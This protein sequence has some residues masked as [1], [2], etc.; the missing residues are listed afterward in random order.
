MA[1]TSSPPREDPSSEVPSNRQRQLAPTVGPEASGG[2]NREGSAMGSYDDS[3]AVGR[4]LYAGNFSSLRT[5]SGFRLGAAPQEDGAGPVQVEAPE[6]AAPDQQE[7]VGESGSPVE[8]SI[9]G[10]LSP[11]SGDTQSMDT[12]EFDRKV[13]EYGYGAQPEVDSAQPKQVLAT[14]A[15][16]GEHGSEAADTQSDPQPSRRGSPMS[17]ER[18]RRDPT[19]EDHLSTEDMIAQAAMDAAYPLDVLNTP[20]TP[21][22]VEALEAKRLELLATAKKIKNT[23]AAILEERKDAEIFVSGYIQREKEVDEGLVKVKE[24]RKHW[25]DKIVEAH[26]EVEKLRRDMITPRRITFA[27][28]TGQQ[29]LATPKDNMTKAAELLKKKDEEIDIDFVRKL[30][31]SAVQQQSKAD[32]SRRLAS[33]PDICVSTAQKD[34]PGDQHR[35]DESRT[36]STERRREAREHP[37]P[38]PVPSDSTPRDPARGKGPMYTGRDKYRVPSPPPRASR[39]PLPPRRRSPAGIPRPH[40][41]GGISIRDAMPAP[42]DRNRERTLEQLRGRNQ[43]REQEPRRSQERDPEPRRSQGRDPEPR[44][45]RN[46]ERDPEPRRS[47]NDQGSQR[48]DEGSHRS[49]SQHREDRGEYEGGSRRSDRPPRRSPSPPPSGG[50]GGGGGGGGRRS[51]SRSKS[52]R[53]GSRDA[54]ERLNEYRTDYIGP[55]CFGRMIR[56]EPKPRS[57]LKLPGNLKHY[58]GTERP[59][60]WIEDYYNAVTFA[61]GTPN[62][63]CRM[64]QLYLV[65]P[66]RIWLSDLEKN[67]IFCWFDLKTA[68]EKHFRGTYKRPATASDLQAC[69]QKKGESSRNFLTRWLACRNECENVDHTTAMYAFIGGLQR[70]GLLRHK[71]TCLANANKLTLDEM[72]SIASDHT[73][74]DDDAGGDIAATAIPLHQQKKNRDNGNNSGHKRKNPDDQKSGGSDLVAVAFQRGGS[75]GGR[76]RGRGGG[77]GRGQPQ[78]S[79]VTAGGSR[80][81]QTYEEYRDMPCLAHLDPVTGKSTHT[82]RNC[83][84]VNDLKNDPEAGYKRAR[85]HRPR[86]KGGKGKNKD[87]DEDSSEA[88]EED[89]NSPDPKSGTAGKSN[90]FDKKSVGAYHT[91][92]GTPT[93]RATKSAARILNAIVPA[94]PQYVRWSEIPCTF[95]REDHPVIVPKE[96][97]ALVVSPRIDG[98]DFSKCLMDGGASLNIMYLETLERMNL[99][100]EQLKHSTTEFHG[101]VPGKKANSLG[102]ITLPVAFGDVHN[103][104]EERITFE[105]VPFKS[106]YHV[107]FGRPTYHKFHARACY[108]YNKLKIPGPKGATYQRTMQRCLKDQI[109]R[110]VHAYVDDIAVMTRKGSDLISDLTETFENLR[111]YKMMLN[112]L[113]CVFGVPAGKL[114]GFIV[115]NRGIEVNPEKIKAILCIKR[116]TCLKDVQRLTGCVAAISRFVS[117]LG[118]K[119]LPLYKLLKKTDKFVWDEAADAALQGLKEILTSPPILAAPGESE[120]MLLYLAATNRVISLVIVVERQEE[121]HEY[122]VQRPVYYISEVLTESKQRYPHFQKLAYGVFLG[123]RKLRHYFQEHPVTVVSKAPLSTILNN[124]DATGRTAKWGIELSAFDISYKARTAVKSQVLADFVAD[125]TEAPDAS[126]EPEPETWVMHFDG[127]KQHQGSGAGVTLKS[128]TGE[129]LQYVLQ[130][131]FEATN[132]MAEYEALLHGLRIAKEIGIKHIICCGDSDLVAQQVAGTWN[133]RNSV[134]AAYR[135]EVDEIAKCFLGY[136]VKYVRRDDNTAADMLSKLGSGRKPIPPGIFLEHLRI[137]SVKG[138]NPENPEVAVSPAKEVMAIIPAWTQPFLDYLI[139][140]KL[141]EDEVLA[142]QIIRRARSYTIVDGQLYKRSATGVFL[143]CVSNQDGIEILRE[144]HAGDCGHHAAPRSL[145]AKAFRSTGFTPFFLVYGSEAVI[146]S[147]IIHDSPRVSA[148]NE[149]TADE[150]RQL[151]VDLI[152]EARNLADQRS[153][154]YQQKLRRYHSRRVRNRSFMAGD[155]VLR[156]RQVKDHKLQSPWEGPFV[157]SKV[158]HNGSYYLVDFRELRD[159]PANWRRKRKRED[160]DDIYDETDRPWNIAQLRPFHT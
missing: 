109:G 116:P 104:R 27:T 137:P 107:I 47:R 1:P 11:I 39:P 124:A 144:I 139:D 119:A 108:I 149:E 155:L 20:I 12:E 150:A 52:P 114:L 76:G 84:W 14:I 93:V 38:I 89:D 157:V 111:R 37:N 95:D 49:R 32:T 57:S 66:A 25:E 55:K 3:I 73:A 21:D 160:P 147:D 40:G 23:A 145:V 26:H 8:E 4:V 16:L 69:I 62:I 151:S 45:S 31:A 96:C 156:L 154:I 5:N 78:G 125:W 112:P 148:Y 105:V 134:M 143:K 10:N 80:A 129:E 118:E 136:E 88:M 97:Y 159:R 135:D 90:P 34:A 130:I 103:F 6:N 48:H 53:H 128:P 79:E 98:Y 102:S 17:R 42:R 117:R 67:T 126:L 122:G 94:V 35:D 71:L 115:S 50:D 59:D 36:G 91:F 33:N 113:K 77:A 75:G 54:R 110:N 29:P 72:I 92:L 158:L 131:H 61:G 70:G 87:K 24:L 65:G 101:V 22:D 60:T 2:R 7:A 28:P 68:F 99:T 51:R 46:E 63:A 15:A 44:R 85:K 140:Q 132:N 121:G 64:L 13:K 142:R 58:D 83:K 106:S 86:G 56:E 141:P 18:P 30:V 81:P 127:S 100:K 74:A 19:P 153:A 120:P 138:A 9:L 82:N 146:P 43:N 41:P 123:S 152:E 133:A